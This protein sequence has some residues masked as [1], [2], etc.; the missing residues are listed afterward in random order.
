M[1]PVPRT[2][3]TLYR[4]ILE[5]HLQNRGWTSLEPLRLHAHSLRCE[6]GIPDLTATDFSF[7]AACSLFI[8]H[9]VNNLSEVYWFMIRD[10]I[11]KFLP[12][13]F[14]YSHAERRCGRASCWRLCEFV[15]ACCRRQRAPVNH[16]RDSRSDCINISTS[17][18]KLVHLCHL[19]CETVT[20]D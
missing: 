12:I 11:V 14:A 8:F 6:I 10:L 20:C 16:R 4:D 18:R 9:G 17:T 15:V 1:Q 19:T 2:I 3:A 5:S 13:G 7:R